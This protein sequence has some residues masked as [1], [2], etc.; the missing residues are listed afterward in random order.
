MALTSGPARAIAVLWLA[1]GFPA[2]PAAAASCTPLAVLPLRDVGG[3]LLVPADLGG[4]PVSLLVDTGSDAGLL[5]GAVVRALGLPLGRR[6]V[7]TLE[8]T[9]GDGRTVPVALVPRLVLGGLAIRDVPFPVGTLPA[10][11]NVSPAVAGLVG[12]DLLAGFAL[13]IDVPDGRLAL[14]PD[15]PPCNDT[16]VAPGP[17]DDV[18]LAP[19]GDRRVVAATLDGRAITALL[20]TGARSRIVSRRTAIAVGVSPALLDTEPGGIT[21]G[22]DLRDALYHWHRFDRLRI[23]DETERDPVL[24][25]LPLPDGGADM[26]LGADWFASHRV[27][28]SYRTNRMLVQRT[29]PR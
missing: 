1:L 9:G 4:I 22:I 14:L 3:Y 19:S 16:P 6:R 27:V 7:A 10:A 11:P 13:A 23:G 15:S 18:P 2:T 5:A 26:L 20:D 17:A 8:G 21:A 24:T 29:A 25:V 28:V 12:A